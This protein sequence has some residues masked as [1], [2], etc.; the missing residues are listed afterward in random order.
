MAL[1]TWIFFGSPRRTAVSMALYTVCLGGVA[2]L[3][4]VIVGVFLC[5]LYYPL[6][7][8]VRRMHSLWHL[9]SHVD[10]APPDTTTTTLNKYAVQTIRCLYAEV[11]LW[12]TVL[13]L[14]VTIGPVYALLSLLDDYILPTVTTSYANDICCKT[15]YRI[16]HDSLTSIDGLIRSRR[17]ILFL[18]F[19]FSIF[20]SMCIL[21]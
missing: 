8:V 20:L 21:L 5:A 18:F 1:L 14:V 13:F 16:S 12:L 6:V 11:L 3:L 15:V 4:S 7:C 10:H 2:A 17:L 19:L 9:T